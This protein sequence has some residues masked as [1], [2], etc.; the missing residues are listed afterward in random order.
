MA[1]ITAIRKSNARNR[2]GL[3]ATAYANLALT[4]MMGDIIQPLSRP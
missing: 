4:R 1:L 2:L 3:S